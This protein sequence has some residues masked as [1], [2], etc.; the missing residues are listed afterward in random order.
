VRNL[1][2][3]VSICSAFFVGVG[4]P[5]RCADLKFGDRRGGYG[6]G[7]RCCG[8]VLGSLGLLNSPVAASGVHYVT[9]APHVGF[10]RILEYLMPMRRPEKAIPVLFSVPLLPLF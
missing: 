1:R 5:A 2:S 6:Q 7:H 8:L 3:G 4:G 9:D 10:A